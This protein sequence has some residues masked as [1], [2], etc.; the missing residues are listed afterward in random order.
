MSLYSRTLQD[1][2]EAVLDGDTTGS[3]FD[4]IPDPDKIYGPKGSDS[5][6]E[7]DDDR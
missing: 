4:F 2:P 1:E 5:E 7:T 6:E 3:V